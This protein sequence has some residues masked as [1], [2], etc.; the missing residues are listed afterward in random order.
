MVGHFTPFVAPFS[1]KGGWQGTAGARGRGSTGQG[2]AG[3]SVVVPG[4]ARRGGTSAPPGSACGWPPLIPPPPF[5][6]LNI[7]YLTH[8]LPLDSGWRASCRG[9]GAEGDLAENP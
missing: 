5:S 3:T 8:L 7:S 4:S 6:C 2:R 9:P 1:S